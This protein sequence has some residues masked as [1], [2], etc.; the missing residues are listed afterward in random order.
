MVPQQCA[1]NTEKLLSAFAVN[2]T[3]HC[4]LTFGY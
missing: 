2:A 3:S 1:E 4:A